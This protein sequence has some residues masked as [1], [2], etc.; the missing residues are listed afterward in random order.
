M[1]TPTTIRHMV[2]IFSGPSNSPSSRN[3]TVVTVVTVWYAAS[4]T[5]SPS[6]QY[7]TVPAT[8]TSTTMSV[9]SRSR[10]NVVVTTGRYPDVRASA[11]FDMRSA[12]S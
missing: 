9:A 2:K 1:P 10:A 3:P 6:S 8:N 11:R 7:P 5:D 4:S 12:A